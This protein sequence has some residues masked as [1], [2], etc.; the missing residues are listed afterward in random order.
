MST[1]STSALTDFRKSSSWAV[2][3]AVASQVISKM[4][5]LV[6][7]ARA[8]T[9]W[10]GFRP[11]VPGVSTT[12]TPGRNLPCTAT[13]APIG[14]SATVESTTWR[15]GAV[16]QSASSVTSMLLRVPPANSSAVSR[17]QAEP[18]TGMN[19]MKAEVAIFTSTGDMS[20]SPSSALTSRLLPRLT[21]PMTTRVGGCGVAFIR[22][23]ARSA[24]SGRPPAVSAWRACCIAA[25]RSASTLCPPSPPSALVT[26]TGAFLTSPPRPTAYVAASLP[27][28]CSL[29]VSGRSAQRLCRRC[30]PPGSSRR[31][32]MRSR[33]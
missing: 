19:R 26:V 4:L 9:R 28:G 13:S 8:S 18:V 12:V 32:C 14:S 20:A 31:N 15:P 17:S 23:H 5:A 33:R 25:F 3:G 6:L 29:A 10:L 11:P 7:A 16:T 22:A 1:E 21:S 2:I 24:T 30:R 27:R